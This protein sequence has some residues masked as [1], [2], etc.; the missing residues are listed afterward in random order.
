M[1]D[2]VRERFSRLR[3]VGRAAHGDLP[4]PDPEPARVRWA[5]YLS[6][7]PAR[8]A[9]W[10]VNDAGPSWPTVR[11]R[12]GAIGHHHLRSL[13]RVQGAL[14]RGGVMAAVTTLTRRRIAQGVEAC[15]YFE[16]DD[17]ADLWRRIPQAAASPESAD[18][19]DAEHREHLAAGRP[20]ADAIRRKI[21]RRPQDFPLGPI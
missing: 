14:R 15:R 19:F 11:P 2:A 7:T 3:A 10:P 1:G 16:L 18:S 21:A 13:L 6:Q 5:A 4:P 20:L 9:L 8:P 12:Y 17:L